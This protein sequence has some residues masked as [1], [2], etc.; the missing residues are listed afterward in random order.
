MYDF[1]ETEK[2]LRL[3]HGIKSD[4]KGIIDKE[5]TKKKYSYENTKSD[6]S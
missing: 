3:L 1:V 6:G 5:K 4:I 2:I